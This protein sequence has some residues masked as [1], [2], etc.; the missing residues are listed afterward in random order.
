MDENW[1][2]RE[3]EFR[4]AAVRQH[5]SVFTIGNGYLS[6]RGAFEEGFLGDLPATLVH[7]VF[8]ELVSNDV[9]PGSPQH[10]Q[11]GLG[12][13]VAPEHRCAQ[14]TL[15]IMVF[16]NVAGAEA[17]E[18]DAAGHKDSPKLVEDRSVLGT[19]YVDHRVVGHET[20]EPPITE[21]QRHEVGL[22]EVCT[23]TV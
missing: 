6:T 14:P 4:R 10:L 22:R 12:V 21:R 9:E 18:R 19:R 1:Y 17:E 2:V 23:G 8:D 20:V 7:G 13:E 16:G 11:V 3:T 5:E 15:R